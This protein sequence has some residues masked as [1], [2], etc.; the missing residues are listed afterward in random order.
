VNIKDLA[1]S[2]EIKEVNIA[3]QGV[4]TYKPTFMQ[5]DMQFYRIMGPVGHPHLNSDMSMLGMKEW[6]IIQ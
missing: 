3:L 2:E 6:G 1:T 4:V 5:G